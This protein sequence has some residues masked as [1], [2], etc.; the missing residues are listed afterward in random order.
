[1]PAKQL[2]IG[3]DESVHAV[4]QKDNHS[5]LSEKVCLKYDQNQATR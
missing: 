4:C 1:M 3:D 2:P 5:L